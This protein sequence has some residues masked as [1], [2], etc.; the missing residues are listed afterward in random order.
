MRRQS[1]EQYL[2]EEL[3]KTGQFTAKAE[4]TEVPYPP[5]P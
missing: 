1:A 4:N 3:D 5:Q 2:E